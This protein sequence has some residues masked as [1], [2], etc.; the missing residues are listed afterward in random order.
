[1]PERR[2]R[3][4]NIVKCSK[5]HNDQIIVSIQQMITY[6]LQAF[7]VEVQFRAKEGPTA[8]TNQTDQLNMRIEQGS[9]SLLMGKLVIYELMQEKEAMHGLDDKPTGSDGMHA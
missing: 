8:I 1:M 5:S 7:I 4:P 6:N 2:K 9:V 3:A